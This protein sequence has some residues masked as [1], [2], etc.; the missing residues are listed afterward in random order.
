MYILMIKYKIAQGCLITVPN[1]SSPGLTGENEIFRLWIEV[2][3]VQVNV[4]FNKAETKTRPGK[5]NSGH[6]T[7]GLKIL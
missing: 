4:F 7:T 2:S 1:G 5:G 6:P 3:L